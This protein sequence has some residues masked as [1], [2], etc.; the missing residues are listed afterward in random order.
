M[1]EHNLTIA[2]RN[3]RKYLSQNII[4][5]VGLSASLVCFS[6]C[7]HFS[8]Y[9]MGTDKHFPNYDRIAEVAMKEV[10]G[11]LHPASAMEAE[12]LKTLSM[13]TLE[14]VCT[15][16]GGMPFVCS[17]EDASGKL[18][19]ASLQSID[20]DASFAKVFSVKV[21]AGSWEHASHTPNS[22]VLAASVARRLFGSET[23]AVGRVFNGYRRNGTPYTVQAVMA[24]LPKNISFFELGI[25]A[26]VL[27]DEGSARKSQYAYNYTG[28][29]YGLMPEGIDLD[30]VNHELNT[31]ILPN[32]TH[33]YGEE[34]GERTL[35]AI[36]MGE[37]AAD[38][39][40]MVNG[41]IITFA[42]LILLVGLLNFLHFL[43]GS[44]LNRTHEYSL[45]RMFG[46]RLRA[47]FF[48]LLTQVV[49]ML[50]AAGWLC[51]FLV[52]LTAAH[53]TLPVQIGTFFELDA[54][55][56]MGESLE[57]IGWLFLLCTLICFGVSLYVQRIT[58]QQGVAGV[59][60]AP[61]IRR[62]VGRDL[63]M[64]LQFFICWV[65]VSLTVAF[66]LQGRLTTGT[67]L[68][69][70]SRTEKEEILSIPMNGSLAIMHPNEKLA[71]I[72]RL[73][74]HAGVKETMTKE[75]DMLRSL[76]GNGILTEKGN[77]DSMIDALLEEVSRQYYDF[78]HIEVIRGVLPEAENQI[79]VDTDFAALFDEDILGRSFY[80]RGNDTPY[81]VTAIVKHVPRAADHR[82]LIARN[83]NGW[84]FLMENQ[85]RQAQPYIGH[86]YLKC[87]PGQVEAV[88]QHALEELRKVLSAST[89]PV[90]KTLMKDIEEEQGFEI[91]LQDII[92]FFALVS[93]SITLLGVYSAITLD[94]E[95]RR[96]EVALRKV[97]GARFGDI[98]WLFGRRYFY[99]L[100]IP[101][102]LAFPIVGWILNILSE[103]YTVF[104]DYGFL[105]WAGI[106]FGVALLV[107]LTIL[108]RI[109][110]VARTRPAEEIA[111]G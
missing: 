67:V 42:T 99:L 60:S 71:L 5:V 19:P 73:K 40:A 53:I 14:D 102:A 16:L 59:S 25:E 65:F 108:W 89:E 43:V 26:L 17:Y 57:Y 107:V 41:V 86:V 85:R 61:R 81:T 8:R 106:F 79:A 109:L 31:S 78:M 69:T 12:K 87:H 7:M 34:R 9:I 20:T 38:N 103:E 93:L 2:W 21:V 13:N 111:K 33:F 6:L 49:L 46:C 68:N 97:H 58:I 22:L 51:R 80:L 98:L 77:P 84:I 36:R 39:M 91:I 18:T 4:S 105:F 27:N 82:G 100:V 3:I 76:S 24:D 66:Y 56:L 72:D 62:H 92:L 54:S 23:E 70:L 37:G 74:A 47:L 1:L 11:N 15:L 28:Y 94:T 63:M 45:R 55:R 48:M 32:F 75:G 90:V 44:I 83:K 110:Q 104:I 95:R 88:R 52:E 50:L 10:N 96:R 35:V 64:G 29:I 101:A 30:D